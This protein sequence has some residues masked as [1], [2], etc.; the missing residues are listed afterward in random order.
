MEWLIKLFIKNIPPSWPVILLLD[1][2]SSHYNLKAIKVAA[3]NDIVL[4]CLSPHTTHVA[5][6][7]DVSFFSPLK[8]HWAR[9]CHEYMTDNLVKL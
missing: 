9:V 7:L 3:E 1:G 8:K 5:Q 2:H 6:P 4:F